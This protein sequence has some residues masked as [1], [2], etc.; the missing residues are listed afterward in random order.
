M[1]D[2]SRGHSNWLDKIGFLGGYGTVTTDQF[3]FG[4]RSYKWVTD[5]YEKR[6]HESGTFNYG[7]ARFYK[8]PGE[9]LGKEFFTS[10]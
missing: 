4:Q 8:D 5:H 9:L 1:I 3:G 2:S 7:R 10:T 6:D